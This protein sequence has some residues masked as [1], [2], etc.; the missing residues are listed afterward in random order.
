MNQI[1]IERM[2]DKTKIPYRYHH[3]ESEEAIAPPFICW[4]IPGTNNFSADGTVYFKVK[5]LDIELYT[6]GKDF[7]LE[8]KIETVLNEAGLFWKKTE[9]YIESENMYEVLYEMEV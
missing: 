5:E 4:L 7:L 2:L 1:E 6:D 9:T 3:F 8:E